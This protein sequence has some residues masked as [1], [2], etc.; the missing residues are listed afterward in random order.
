MR[1]ATLAVLALVASSTSPWAADIEANKQLYRNLM[2]DVWN[3][4]QPN[5]I[6]RYLAANFIEHNKNIPADF[7]GRKRFVT[8]LQTGFSDYRAEIV[9]VIAEGDMVVARVVWTGTR[10][11]RSRVGRRRATS[12]ASR[13]PT[14]SVSRTASS[15]NIG[16]WSTVCRAPSRLDWWAAPTPASPQR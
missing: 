9:S 2:E 1:L 10:T 3:K 6:D 8:A 7:E 13:R 16:T 11:A 5:A 14:S 12:C 15:P 4:R